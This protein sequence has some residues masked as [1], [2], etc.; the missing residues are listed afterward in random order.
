[1]N[2][3]D[4]ITTFMPGSSLF[5]LVHPSLPLKPEIKLSYDPQ[6]RCVNARERRAYGNAETRNP[7][8]PISLEFMAEVGRRPFERTTLWGPWG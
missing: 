6:H 5:E 3:N 8:Y 4:E 2:L 1:M 7:N